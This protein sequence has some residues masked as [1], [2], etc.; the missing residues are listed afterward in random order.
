MERKIVDFLFLN[1]ITTNYSG[2]LSST[3][4]FFLFMLWLIKNFLNKTK[5]GQNCQ[6][7]QHLAPC[8]SVHRVWVH[9]K[10]GEV[11]IIMSSEGVVH[12]IFSL[13]LANCSRHTSSILKMLRD[14]W[15]EEVLHYQ[16]M[17]PA[18]HRTLCSFFLNLIQKI[19]SFRQTKW[20]FWNYSNKK[21]KSKSCKCLFKNW[22]YFD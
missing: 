20:I 2:T 17:Q 15:I 5:M 9:S 7:C 22:E 10:K 6:L 3:N 1:L 19:A 8:F 13:A 16:P 14:G 12:L 11:E 21:S 18:M 4:F